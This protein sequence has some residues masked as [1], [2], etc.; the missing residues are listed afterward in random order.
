[1]EIEYE[2]INPISIHRDGVFLGKNLANNELLVIKKRPL[3]V[4]EREAIALR[5]MDIYGIP[6]V[7]SF[8]INSKELIIEYFANSRSLLTFSEKDISTFIEIIPKIIKLI[9]YCHSKGFIHGDIKPSNILLLKNKEV[10]LI[11]FGASLPINTDY[12]LLDSYQYT[13]MKNKEFKYRKAIPSI[14]WNAFKYYLE[15][16]L[17]FCTDDEKLKL[18]QIIKNF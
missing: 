4:L 2:I 9:E 11:D 15:M 8:N 14:D 13:P 12:N 5:N 16:T 7:L 10:G 17:S 3:N 18:E 1:M 6:K